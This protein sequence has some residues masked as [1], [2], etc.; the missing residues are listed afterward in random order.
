MPD[1]ALAPR[2]IPLRRRSSGQEM[3]LD[4]A[5][6]IGVGGEAR[7][8]GI[9]WD[10]GLVAKLYHHPTLEQARKLAL[11][12]EDPPA[13]PAGASIAWPVDLLTDPRGARFAGFLMPRAEGPRVFEFYN[14][15]SRR[16][17]APLFD[18][19]RLHRAG[20]NLAA[21]FDGLHGHGYVIGDVNESNILV[22]PDDASVVL[23]DA[24]SFQV[25]GPARELYR[26]KVGKAEFTPPELQGT[27]FADVDRAP[28]HDRF[29]LAVLLFLLLM[30]GTHPFA[31]RL[32]EGG[33]VPPVEE[34]IL[35]GMFP[36][37]RIGDEF[38]PPRMAP[39]FYTL[40]PPVQAL[41]LRAFVQGQADPSARPGGAE[42]RAA[43]EE[44]EA[45]LATCAANPRHRHAPHVDFCPWC[46]RSKLLQGRD[47]FPATVDLAR[48]HDAPPL[49]RPMPGPP[50]PGVAPVPPRPL[51]PWG[52]PPAVQ[53]ITPPQP[54]RISVWASAALAQTRAALP[55]WAQPA[56][57]PDAL[58]NPVVWMPPAALT[59]LFGATGG[60][61]VLGMMVFFLALR[62][63][64]RLNTLRV[65]PVTLMW[66]AMLL[67]VWSVV[68]G[69]AFG[70]L[71]VNRAAEPDMYDVVTDVYPEPAPVTPLANALSSHAWAEPTASAAVEDAGDVVTV[72]ELVDVAGVNRALD[73]AYTPEYR[74]RGM[75]GDVRLRMWVNNGGVV[76]PASVTVLSAPTTELGTAA[77]S[78]AAQMRFRP[79]VVNQLAWPAT[80][81]VS[82]H[83]AL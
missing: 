5:L 32:A 52:Q 80:V 18:W 8:L 38:R 72:A 45:V 43:L 4:P 10:P 23:V 20:A 83:F 78:V 58:A 13:L 69:V 6:E 67:V 79:V 29:G 48:V 1:T 16:K 50:R 54:S 66:I 77:A 68:S 63:V 57:G 55:P 59:C 70:G 26:S 75:E 22:S 14:P 82:V 74:D 73:A 76:D 17:T 27:H 12:M 41:F 42:W 62:R 31:C 40:H 36:H 33:E 56:L 49:R 19:A 21:A 51:T 64:F 7:V 34:R 3:A 30:E 44:A 60:V 9:R 47:P 37:A 71:G 65:Q 15:V 35:R 24:D 11:M 81:T 53:V 2:L 25:R 46:H 28:E 39:P 61:R